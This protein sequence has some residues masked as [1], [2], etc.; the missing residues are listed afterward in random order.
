MSRL[1]S[2]TYSLASG[3][4]P[5]FC[6]HALAVKRGGS[7]ATINPAARSQPHRKSHEMQAS[8]RATPDGSPFHGG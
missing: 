6:S 1:T 5:H 4:L 3:L 2:R 7:P 8:S